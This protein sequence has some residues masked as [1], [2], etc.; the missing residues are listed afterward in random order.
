MLKP[1]TLL[2]PRLPP[3][4]HDSSAM[5]DWVLADKLAPP[6][7]RVA[8][9]PRE[10]LLQHLDRAAELPLTLL[11][12]PPGF[13]KTTLLGQWHQ[14]LRERGE[15]AVAW[16]SLDED[17]ADPGRFLAYLALA[18]RG[19]G[20]EL[21]ASLQ[22]TLQQ[23]GQD[24][25]V[26]S[27]LPV[28]IRAIRAAPRRLLVILDDYDRGHAS[29]LDEVVTRLVEHAGG[30]LHLLL[31]TRRAPA[32][33]LARWAL[34]GQLERIG[35]RELALDEAETLALLG[36]QVPVAMARQLRR[37]TEG[38]AVALQLAG[39][40]LGGDE[41]RRDDLGRFSGRTA[42][43][44]AY[45]AEQVLNDL[46]PELRALLLQLSP[47]ERFNAAL[48]DA[49]RER[50]DS[51]RLLER[52]AHFQGLLVA[53][54]GEH[55]WFRFHPLFADYLYQQLERDTPGLA[56]QLHRRAAHWFDAH[57]QLPEAVRH[58]VRGGAIDSAADCIA[59]A[60]TWQLLLR[61]GTAPIRALLRRFPRSSIGERPALNLTQ[62]YLHMKLGEFAHA[63]TLLERF[64]DFPEHVRAPFERDYTVVVALLRDLLDQVCAN[65]RGLAQI[66]AQAAALDEDDGLGRGTLWCIC[67]T[68]ALG[69]ADF[70]GAERY[71]QLAG[72]AMQAGGSEVGASYALIH[73]AQS[74]Y[75]RG[76]LERAEATCRQALAIAQRQQQL[77]PTL[78]AVGQCLLAQLQCE[79]GRYDEAADC[80]QPALGF[81]EQHDGW[82]DIYAA[83]YET[84]LVLARQHDR[85]GRAAL[86][87]LDHIDRIAHARH[88]GR[89]ADLALAWRLHVLLDQPP[90]PAIDVLV[91]RTGGEARFA[92]ALGQPQDWRFL[93]ALGFALARWHRLGGRTR[94]ALA[95]LQGVEA[96]C[97][98]ADNQVHLARVRARM[99]LVLHDRGESAAA[100]PYLRHALQ[101]VASTQAWQCLLELGVPG[102]ALL[103]MARQQDPQAAPN[104]TLAMTIQALLDKLR[105]DQDSGAELFSERELEVLALLAQ[106]DANKQIAR[107]LALSENTVKFHLKNL[108]RK[109]EAGTREAALASALQR[110][111]LQ[112][113][114]PPDTGLD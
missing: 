106:G 38:W 15:A 85:S 53:L 65:P 102:K 70:A 97:M 99:A 87:L 35:A 86:D 83:G 67:A 80:L 23:H 76:H 105:H 46:D 107:R 50:D 75:Y 101:H 98:A 92:H 37:Q 42:E 11:L 73:L 9:V 33:P 17:D 2:N 112:R 8:A 13:G 30:Q 109:L 3:A 103:R 47:L 96:A 68:T 66:A 59:R 58:A 34:Q 71:A 32:L 39:L 74:H 1:V 79:H 54:D 44:A 56:P 108:Y 7:S 45:L 19:A 94:A 78:Q 28:L 111:L 104:T 88:L 21:G 18:A 5:P 41:R 43:L 12:A 14:R 55:E 91:A 81:L 90:S 48:A 29:A 84:A 6:R 77:D 16:L 36:P 63:Q 31:A 64:R 89:L 4:V 95:V 62:A 52:L 100:L 49:V 93:A 110:G 113:M 24:L 114:A 57:G 60:G 10:A 61:H 20:I 72:S 40:W 69:R 22:A 51:G 82:L 27:T 25:E 26:A